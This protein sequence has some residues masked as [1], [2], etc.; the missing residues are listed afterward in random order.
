VALEA[1][2]GSV[3]DDGCW[4]IVTGPNAPADTVANLK[5]LLRKDDVLAAYRND[6]PSL[7]AR[8]RLSISQAGYNTCGDLLR[9]DAAMVLAPFAQGSEREQTLRAARLE[10]LGRAVVVP[11][12]GL[13]V[14][15]M[16]AAIAGAL[17]LPSATLKLK[18][19]GAAETARLLARRLNDGP[20]A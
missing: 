16:R 19:D 8:T 15:A 1:R 18:L 13:S 11:E 7:L 9:G 4:C 3:I 17:R 6:L 5:T 20:R 14:E 2:R 10:A 12:A